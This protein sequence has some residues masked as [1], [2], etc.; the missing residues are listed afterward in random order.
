MTAIIT[1]T[2]SL[3]KKVTLSGFNGFSIP[4]EIKSVS[5][6]RG[7]K[8][9]LVAATKA[10]LTSEATIGLVLNQDLHFSA[11]SNGIVIGSG[12]IANATLSVGA[13]EVEP[14]LSLLGSSKASP[15]QFKQVMNLASNFAMGLPTDIV[16]DDFHLK[17]ESDVGW[18][19]PALKTMSLD[20]TV[21]GVPT[22][23]ITNITVYISTALRSKLEIPFTGVFYNS[24]DVP[25]Y[26]GSLQGS[27]FFRGT[28]IAT[29]DIPSISPPLYLP[30]KQLT[31]SDVPLK[32]KALLA[33]LPLVHDINTARPALVD[34][35]ARVGG[36]FGEYPFSMVYNQTDVVAKVYCDDKTGIISPNLC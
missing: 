28:R 14:V 30:P 21:P 15:T 31:V 34:I 9:T 24:F 33:A 2:V 18:L 29:V 1:T 22:P 26:L 10:T 5:M 7:T 35:R 32:G 19:K 4:P 17:K 36:H 11:K 8:D 16:L 12:V 20:A 13:F 27:I 25:I 3:D 6:V 23:L